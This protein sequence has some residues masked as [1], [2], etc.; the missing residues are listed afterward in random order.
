MLSSLPQ[1]LAN[2]PPPFAL[3]HP[4]ELV[5]FNPHNNNLLRASPDSP[6]ASRPH[7]PLP[8]LKHPRALVLN[9]RVKDKPRNP[10]HLSANLRLRHSSLNRQWSSR[11]PNVSFEAPRGHAKSP[12]R[13]SGAE[14]IKAMKEQSMSKRLLKSA[15]TGL[16]SLFVC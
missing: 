14:R 10:N 7:Q 16:V 8:H 6:S 9:L 3:K 4:R 2:L 12:P 5:L 1:A 15:G 11:R 13:P